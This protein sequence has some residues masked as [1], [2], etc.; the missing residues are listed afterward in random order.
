LPG[1]H[2][3]FFIFE[4]V[5]QVVIQNFL[6]EKKFARLGLAKTSIKMQSTPKV[7]CTFFNV[8]F[9]QIHSIYEAHLSSPHINHPVRGGDVE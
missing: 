6:F 7:D 9:K 3:I 8:C 4:K 2:K 5:C 1:C